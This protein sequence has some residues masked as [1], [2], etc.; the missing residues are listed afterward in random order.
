MHN[1]ALLL[2]VLFRDEFLALF[3]RC[4]HGIDRVDVRHRLDELL[5]VLRDRRSS[6]GN[7]SAWVFSWIV[8]VGCSSASRLAGIEGAVGLLGYPLGGRTEF[9]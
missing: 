9:F 1:G 6:A 7:R 5:L 3:N 2:V 4:V 8:M